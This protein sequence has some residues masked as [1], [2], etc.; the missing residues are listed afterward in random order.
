MTICYEIQR[1]LHYDPELNEYQ[2]KTIKTIYSNDKYDCTPLIRFN[3]F[4]QNNPERTFRL[5]QVIIADVQKSSHEVNGNVEERY[6]EN[7]EKNM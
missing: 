1:Y 3:N 2:Y 5:I 6:G 7:E 4:V